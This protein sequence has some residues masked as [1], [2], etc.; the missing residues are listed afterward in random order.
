M[1]REV[2]VLQ[3]KKIYIKHKKNIS[4]SAI[5]YPVN[6]QLLMTGEGDRGIAYL[7]LIMLCY[8]SEE[9]RPDFASV[10]NWRW[11]FVTF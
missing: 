1:A 5:R 10:F 3:C 4:N 6:Y 11:Q 7:M 9:F 2:K 8:F